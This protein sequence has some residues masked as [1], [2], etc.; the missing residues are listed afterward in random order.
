[1][2]ETAGV[3]SCAARALLVRR[4]RAAWALISVAAGCWLG[5]DLLWTLS[6]QHQQYP[7]IA[8]ALYL[9]WYPLCAAGIVLLLTGRRGGEAT[10][11]WIDGAIAALGLAAVATA[12]LFDALLHDRNGDAVR[13]FVELAYPIAD[14]A[15]VGLVLIAFATQGWRP[16]RGWLLLGVGAVG[17]AVADVVYLVEVATGGYSESSLVSVLW[18]ASL[19]CWAWAAWQPW[20]PPRRRRS[21]RRELFLVPTAFALA[22]VAVLFYG[23]LRTIPLVASLLALA[24]LLLSV[25]RA[26]VN[27]RQLVALLERSRHE[28]RTDTLTGLPNRRSLMDD[29]AAALADGPLSSAVTLAFFD[30]DGFKGYN[31][32]FGHRAGDIV[33]TRVATALRAAVGKAGTA[34]RLGGDEFC[35]LL[36]GRHPA[37]GELLR[38]C[39]AALG[40]HGEGFELSASMGAVALPLEAL[41]PAQALSLADERMYADKAARPATRRGTCDVLM[42]VLRER[43]PELRDHSDGVTALAL[44][45]GR[46]L[47]LSAEQLDEVARAAELHDIGKVAIP[48]AI[49][50]KEGPLDDCEWELM[51]QHT[52]IGDRILQASPAMRPVARLVRASH[53]R[54]DGRGYPDGLAGEEIPLGARIVAVCDSY[55]AMTSERPYQQRPATHE[56]AIAELRRCAGQQFDPAVVDAFCAVIFTAAVGPPALS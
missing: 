46:R 16:S 40:S 8:D 29:L 15:L 33:L 25:G 7:A 51:R 55:S 42:Q 47:G 56:Q 3:L 36:D 26:S 32:G 37:D 52:V 49:L 35:L 53:E 21:S 30:L 50:H 27:Y 1:M 6:E 17:I 10:K 24:A 31:D 38:R 11:L 19:L 23:Q 54:W 13:T 22:A 34:Y 41:T 14:L 5:G 9:A 12:L 44:A 45:V 48:E 20:G 43:E 4:R 39:R 2:L 28:A 18:P